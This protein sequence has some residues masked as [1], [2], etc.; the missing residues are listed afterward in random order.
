MRLVSALLVICAVAVLGLAQQ[1]VA[2]GPDT[3]GGSGPGVAKF[4]D[5]YSATPSGCTAGSGYCVGHT[6]QGDTYYWTA[7]LPNASGLP[8]TTG[9]PV[10]GTINDFTLKGCGGNIA[11]LQL[12]TWSWAAPTASHITSVNCMAS[13]GTAPGGIDV[14]VGWKGHLTSSDASGN[15]SWKSRAPFSKG[16]VLYLPVERQIPAGGQ[17]IHDASF[18]MSP[19]SGKHWC[20]PYSLHHGTTPGTCDSS[21]WD[22]TGDAPKCDATSTSTPCANAAYLDAVHSS[23]MWKALPSGT[24]NWSWV[25]Y[26]YQDGQTPP[27]GINDGCDPA[28][29][30][31]FMLMSQDGSL[32]RVPN[33]SNILDISAWQYYTCPAVTENY[34]C[35]GS[36]PASWTSDFTNR[37]SVMYLTCTGCTFNPTFVNP[38]TIIYLKE[39]HSYLMVAQG[40]VF[41]QAPNIQGPWTTAFRAGPSS[42]VVANFYSSSPALGYNVISTNP[43]HIQLTL[44]A[45]SYSGGQGSPQFVLE[46]L[47][48]GKQL[49]G[50]TFQLSN[51]NAFTQGAGYQFSTGNIAGTFPRKGLVWAFDFL[52]QGVNS[53]VTNWPYFVDVGNHSVVMSSCNGGSYTAPLLCGGMNPGRGTSITKYGI[54]T[55]NPAY[56]GHFHV[57]PVASTGFS[58][59]LNVSPAMLGNGSYSVMGVY[60]YEGV[61]NYRPGGIWSA[62]TA[63][64]SDNASV[65]LNQNSGKLQLDW[66]GAYSPRY[67]Y[68]ANFTFPNYSNWYFMAVTVQAQTGGCGANCVPTARIWVG[69]AVIPGQLT[70]VNAG[71]A[72]TSANSPATKTPNVSAGP[73]VMGI[74]GT[75]SGADSSIMS[76]ATTMVYSR[77]LTYPEIQMMY[78][79]M[80]AKMAARGVT[81][82]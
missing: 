14:P 16:G 59:S 79:S 4:F 33:T 66:N 78:R 3:T 23:I 49:S 73:F 54:Q 36:D 24:E 62:G 21:N 70:D 55:T 29:Y 56:S 13:Y 60:R 18:L 44:N 67:Q 31:C 74:N 81:L 68:L 72:Y 64:S 1:P 65:A 51:I 35:S 47:V 15:G 32:A 22:A 75:G 39:F 26:G 30:T 45:N 11:V 34:R 71:V 48:L 27:S 9:L 63:S 20:N 40:T 77:A 7:W 37:T 41:A 61:T 50:E 28:T 10:V 17:G 38:Y 19:D 46:D 52:D 25:N 69:G 53:S 42:L 2:I 8:V 43:P 6:P 57:F 58:T 12:D 76:Y 80:M 5:W 82:Q